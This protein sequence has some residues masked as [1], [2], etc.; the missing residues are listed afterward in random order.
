M[1]S[2]FSLPPLALPNGV[3]SAYGTIIRRTEDPRDIEYRVF[4]QVTAALQAASAADAPFTARISAVHRNRELWQTLAC[5]LAGDDNLL[6]EQLRAK[7]IS[8][9]I[10]VTRETEQVMHHGAPLDDLIEINR[11]IMQGLRPGALESVA[12]PSS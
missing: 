4:E 2:D 5:D 9:A 10:W 3:A 12:C 6:P 7:L 11:S 1:Q 8:L